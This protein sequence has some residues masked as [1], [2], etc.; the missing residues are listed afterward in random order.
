MGL[1]PASVRMSVCGSIPTLSNMNKSET[2]WLII[3][4]IL[5]IIGV[6]LGFVQ[7]LVSMATDSSHRVSENISTCQR[8]GGGMNPGHEECSGSVIEC[9]TGNQEVADSSRTRDSVLYLSKTL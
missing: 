2:S 4:V 3:F 9:L 7:I 1:E 5:S 8:G 6:A